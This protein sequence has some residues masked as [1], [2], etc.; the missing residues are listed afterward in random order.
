MLLISA[1]VNVGLN[2]L[3]IPVLGIF[4]AALATLA[5]Y[6]IWNS[7]RIHFSARFFDLH[8]ELRRMFF[9][10][11]LGLTLCGAGLLVASQ[12]GLWL[13]LAVKAMAIAAYPMLVVATGL[14]RPHERELIARALRNVRDRGLAGTVKAIV[15]G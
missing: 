1:L 5:S 9:L 13:G 6:L 2:I 8:F 3:L 12:V 14:I 15:L 7:L 10:T 4:G 11:L